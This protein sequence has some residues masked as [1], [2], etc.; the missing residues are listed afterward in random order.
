M[1]PRRWLLSSLFVI[2]V[3]A[4]G[5]RAAGE[6]D[7]DVTDPGLTNGPIAYQAGTRVTITTL[8]TTEGD[9]KALASSDPRFPLARAADPDWSPS[10]LRLAFTRKV[11]GRRQIFLTGGAGGRTEPLFGAATPLAEAYEPTWSDTGAYL[12][13]TGVRGGLAP[14]IF[15]VSV[16][17]LLLEQLTDEPGGASQ[18]DWSPGGAWIAFTSART[19][20][21]D[22]WAV[23]PRG[24]GARRISRGTGS[25]TDRRVATAP[26]PRDRLRGH[27]PHAHAHPRPRRRRRERAARPHASRARMAGRRRVLGAVGR[28]AAVHP[29]QRKGLRDPAGERRRRR[30]S[31]VGARD[32][33]GNRERAGARCRWRP[34]ATAP[35]RTGRLRS[36]RSAMTRSRSRRP[37]ARCRTRSRRKGRAFR[38]AFSSALR[39]ARGSMSSGTLPAPS[40]STW[41]S[42]GRSRSSNP[43]PARRPRSAFAASRPTARDPT[44]PRRASAREQPRRSRRRSSSSRGRARSKRSRATPGARPARPSGASRRPAPAIVF[45]VDEGQVEVTDD[46]RPGEVQIAV[47]GRP[48]TVPR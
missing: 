9:P 42:P 35:L 33:R 4:A 48:V 47:P 27:D 31:Q 45:T 43:I 3:T 24:T 17:G 25:E 37:T 18:P 28:G 7:S 20:T 26:R 5:A 16:K 10:G 34:T 29:R 44:P 1:R 21:N 14:Q 19:G 46:R 8:G 6:P 12:A 39:V 38:R 32:R 23:S 11:D 2:A 36:R 30:V 13:F 15:R 41:R 22:I 40:R